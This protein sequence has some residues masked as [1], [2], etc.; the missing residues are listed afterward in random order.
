MVTFVLV[1]KVTRRVRFGKV[2]TFNING[3]AVGK[4]Q[5]RLNIFFFF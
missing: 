4:L 2:L 3:T 5:N 1:S